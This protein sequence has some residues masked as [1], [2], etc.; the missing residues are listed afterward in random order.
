MI[1]LFRATVSMIFLLI[2][3]RVFSS[4]FY[5]NMF[6]CFLLFLHDDFICFMNLALAVGFRKPLDDVL[7][8]LLISRLLK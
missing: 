1:R 3:A 6:E 4:T 7:L 8:V 2:F 5:F